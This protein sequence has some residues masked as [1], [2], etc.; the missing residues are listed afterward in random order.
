MHTQKVVTSET[1]DLNSFE[2]APTL[3]KLFALGDRFECKKLRNDVLDAFHQHHVESKRVPTPYICTFALA[4]LPDSSKL[5]T[6][7]IDP[8]SYNYPREDMEADSAARE[9]LP[10]KTLCK[11]LIINRRL[12]RERSSVR[13]WDTDMCQYH[14]HSDGSECSKSGRKP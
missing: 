9:A 10:A 14:D 12:V 13:P 11:M 4:H 3:V 5:Y 8:A 7:M 1:Q 2:H 6:Y